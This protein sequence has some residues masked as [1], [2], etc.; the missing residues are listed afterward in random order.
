MQEYILCPAV[1]HLH[2]FAFGN[3]NRTF[4]QAA[5][6]QDWSRDS[7]GRVWIN[8]AE[9]ENVDMETNDTL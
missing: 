1:S 2:V 7:T 3:L 6:N 9:H 4:I 5:P 8:V